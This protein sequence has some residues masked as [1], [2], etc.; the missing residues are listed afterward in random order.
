MPEDR[1]EVTVTV[2]G[3]RV[4]LEGPTDFVTAEVRRLTALLHG[5]DSPADRGVPSASGSSE[6]EFVAEKRPQNHSEII[7]CLAFALRESGGQCF[8]PEEI[9]RAYLR[10]KLRPPKVISQAIRDAKNHFDYVQPG[11]KRGTYVLSAHG[12]RTVLFDLPREASK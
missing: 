7:A 9:R 12:E 5:Q 2:E 11:E 3:K 4:T 10:A 8:T 1:I 6:A